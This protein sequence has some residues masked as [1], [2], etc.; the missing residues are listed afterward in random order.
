MQAVIRAAL[1]LGSGMY[2]LRETGSYAG[3]YDTNNYDDESM[4]VCSFGTGDRC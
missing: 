1:T 2:T 4:R 3:T